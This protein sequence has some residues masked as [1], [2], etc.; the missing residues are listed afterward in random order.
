MDRDTKDGNVSMVAYKAAMSSAVASNSSSVREA[1]DRRLA[2]NSGLSQSR[3][4][5]SES[6]ETP[7]NVSGKPVESSGSINPAADGSSAH[8]LP[9]T[10]LLRKETR[11]MYV[12]GWI[13]WEFAN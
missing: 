1:Y 11:G 8:R 10:V 2:A 13:A 12:K 4:M 6:R 5:V 7:N 3:S 9:A